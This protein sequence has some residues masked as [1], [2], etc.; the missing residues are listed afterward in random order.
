MNYVVRT[1]KTEKKTY[2]ARMQE[3]RA[4]CFGVIYTDF[5]PALGMRDISQEEI[6]DLHNKKAM[7]VIELYGKG[8]LISVYQSRKWGRRREV[9]AFGED[10]K[11]RERKRAISYKKIPASALLSEEYREMGLKH[12]FSLEKSLLSQVFCFE[13]DGETSGVVQ[14]KDDSIPALLSGLVLVL[15]EKVQNQEYVFEFLRD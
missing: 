12:V 15:A 2:L 9:A 8:K 1:N 5:Q 11:Y 7:G 10:G 13:K 4:E 3:G 6:V 14:A